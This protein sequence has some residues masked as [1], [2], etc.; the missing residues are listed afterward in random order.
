M[1]IIHYLHDLTRGVGYGVLDWDIAASVQS[2]FT[3]IVVNLADWL[4]KETGKD[5][6]AYSGGCA[7]NC[8]T[9]GHISNYVIFQRYCYTTCLW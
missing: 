5:K 7:L 1:V 6:L 8:V 4:H 2:V 3:D 9:N